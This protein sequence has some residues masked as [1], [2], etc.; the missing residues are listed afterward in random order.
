M[1]GGRRVSR[2]KTAILGRDEHGRLL[3]R[4]PPLARRRNRR[5][6]RRG[7]L[8]AYGSTQR[9]GRG[10]LVTGSEADPYEAPYNPC[11]P[12]S[13]YALAVS[14]QMHEYDTTREQLA[15][16]AVAAREWAKLNPKA[17]MRE[18][19][20]VEDVVALRMVS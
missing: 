5:R 4:L 17:F 16:V 7:A 18:D 3:V 8:V 19:L 20:T 14:R 10:R 11:Y 12:V 9:S 1:R 6:A 13:M 2:Y 15:E